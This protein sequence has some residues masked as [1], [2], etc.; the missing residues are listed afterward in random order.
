MSDDSWSEHLSPSGTGLERQQSSDGREG[1]RR[2]ADRQAQAHT[3]DLEADV[4]GMRLLQELSS[5]LLQEEDISSLFIDIVDAAMAITEADKGNIQLLDQATQTL[6]VVGQRGFAPPFLDFFQHIHHGEATCGTALQRGKRVII[7]DV[8]ESPVFVGKPSLAVM[9]ESNVRAVQ[10][11]PLVG[12]SGR[13]V[14]ILST[15]YSRPTYPTPRQLQVLDV[16][17]RQAADLIERAHTVQALRES[18]DQLRRTVVD[19][20][21]SREALQEKVKDLE[22]FH[23]VVVGRELK[24]MELEQEVTELRQALAACSCPRSDNK[25]SV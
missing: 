7:E 23:D 21:C 15:M 12:R 2:E 4:A 14:G 11:T 1:H 24:M 6:K 13:V 9:L 8:T 10:S 22:T 20:E 18:Q 5:R 16:L 25:H 3:N 19:L 17:A